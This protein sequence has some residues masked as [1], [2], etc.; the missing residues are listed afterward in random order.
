M[1]LLWQKGRKWL[2]TSGPG[3][4]NK[5]QTPLGHLA[6]PTRGFTADVSVFGGTPPTKPLKCKS[7]R[8][9]RAARAWPSGGKQSLPGVTAELAAG[10][11]ILGMSG[12]PGQGGLVDGG[13]VSF[14]IRVS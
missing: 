5:E 10:D 6:M 4:F 9:H 12:P 14:S 2:R 3:H 8:H 11:I 1:E 7:V 13:A